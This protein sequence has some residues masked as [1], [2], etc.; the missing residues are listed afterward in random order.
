MER[1]LA[2]TEPA[3]RHLTRRDLLGEAG[4]DATTVLDGPIVYGLYAGQRADGG[5]GEQPY[6]KWTGAHWRLVSLVELGIPPGEP[7]ALAAAETV[8]AW[9][10]GG[11]RL[12]RLAPPV[13]GLH[14]RHASIDGNA[15]AVCCR[16]GLARDPRVRDL[17]AAIVSWQWPDGGWNCTAKPTAHRSSFHETLATTWGLTEYA[18]ATGDRA[19]AA[20]VARA[21]ELFLDHRLFRT[22]ATGE[23][24]KS[25]F[26]DLHYP[27][28]W[29]YDVLQALL[30]L[31]RAGKAHD[32]RT[33]D[34]VAVIR[35]R[36]RPDGSWRANRRWWKPP[37]SA[38]G[39]PE[40]IDWG[41][42]ADD[43]ATL[44]ALRALRAAGAST[45][46]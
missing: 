11:G 46:T 1:L 30:V 5:F 8:L 21:A 16:L 14:R 39:T 36:Q 13:N 32:R 23:P 40:A 38:T 41:P 4:L 42:V 7:R 34:A 18:Q 28:Y 15:V 43:M 19:A 6:K 20:A 22:L 17:A 25:Q 10:T 24:I 29:H 12:D 37:G 27:P 3:I 35:G 31:G 26:T 9:L 33:A 45:P 44:N 2:S